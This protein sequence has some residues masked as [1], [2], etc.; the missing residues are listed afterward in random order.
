[1]KY[2]QLWWIGTD[3]VSLDMG[4][5]LGETQSLNLSFFAQIQCNF[6]G[7]IIL[8]RMLSFIQIIQS[9]FLAQHATDAGVYTALFIRYTM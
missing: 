9:E 1:M 7:P 8:T 3:G 4:L 6:W 2:R 5:D